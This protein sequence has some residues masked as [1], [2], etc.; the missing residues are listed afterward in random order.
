MFK[1]RLHNKWF[2]IIEV[3]VW[4]FIFILWLASIYMLIS[5]SINLND[6]NKNQIIAANLSREWIELIKNLRDSNYENLH[7][8]NLINPDLNDDFDNSSNYIN[9]WYYKIWLNYTDL[10]STFSV[11]VQKID[12]FKEGA[13]YLSSDMEKYE[14]CLNSDDKYTYDCSWTNTKT[15]FFRY[16]HVENLTYKDSSG[17]VVTVNDAYKVTS[18]VIWYIRWYHE[19]SLVTILADYKKL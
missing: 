1:M 13:S 19:I 4:V 5:S 9:P 17:K 12:D 7:K 11:K 2:S 8:W 15:K 16:I 18:K 14:L 3:M 10:N 6:Y